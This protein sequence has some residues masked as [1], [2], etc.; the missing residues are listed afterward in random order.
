MSC[1][2]T[3]LEVRRMISRAVFLLTY[4]SYLASY[5]AVVATPVDT[6]SRAPAVNRTGRP[7]LILPNSQVPN[8]ANL[9]DRP[10]RCDSKRFGVI[11]NSRSCELAWESIPIDTKEQTWG[12][13]A[14]LN[15]FD[16]VLPH[17]YLSRT[18]PS[19]IASSSPCGPSYEECD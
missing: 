5:N 16:V 13:R 18:S 2:R 15:P 11:T 10:V 6:S 4:F 8:A 19:S 14:R 1:P 9:S 3:R 17:R 7:V 12:P